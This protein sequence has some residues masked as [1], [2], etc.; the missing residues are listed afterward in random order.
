MKVAAAALAVATD[1]AAACSFGEIQLASDGTISDH[2][3]AKGE[4]LAPNTTMNGTVTEDDYD[5]YH[6]CIVRH[7]HEHLIQLDLKVFDGEANLF[8]SS[9]HRYPMRGHATWISQHI[10][11]DHVKLYTYLD[12]FPR[13]SDAKN[14]AIPLHIGV[15]GD[16]TASYKLSVAVLDLPTTA[17]VVA[18]E[19]YYTQRHRTDRQM[20]PAPRLRMDA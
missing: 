10:G 12:G 19:K 8:M 15:F 9:E 18:R 11:D 5:F 3:L 1:G 2:N 13:K 16:T 17:D 6:V 4:H 20:H 14:R 7:E